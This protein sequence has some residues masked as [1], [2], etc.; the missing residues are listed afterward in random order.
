MVLLVVY[1]DDIILTSTLG[2]PFTSLLTNLNREFAM[3]DLDPLY[4]FLGIEA[5]S[6]PYSL[7][8]T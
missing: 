6:S 3:K 2:T 5:T 1:V 8:L 7:H 4:Y